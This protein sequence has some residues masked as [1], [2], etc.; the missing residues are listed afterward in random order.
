MHTSWWSIIK[1][2]KKPPSRRN[3]VLITEYVHYRVVIMRRALLDRLLQAAALLRR[4]RFYMRPVRLCGTR[5]R[6]ETDKLKFCTEKCRNTMGPRVFFLHMKLIFALRPPG[7]S[8]V[9]NSISIWFDY[10]CVDNIFILI[11]IFMT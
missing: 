3:T 10:T 8:L 2:K 11:L 5:V 9:H 1:K 7:R 4:R 6:T